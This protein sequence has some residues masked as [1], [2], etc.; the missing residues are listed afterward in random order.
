LR[1]I[2]EGDMPDYIDIPVGGRFEDLASIA[3][4][5]DREAVIKAADALKRDEAGPGHMA[6]LWA[7]VARFRGPYIQALEREANAI[8]QR[9][10]SLRVRVSSSP[11]KPKRAA[12]GMKARSRH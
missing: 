10:P 7:A 2:E 12:D 6:D 1:Q 3:A 8:R 4:G 9:L 5:T 11:M